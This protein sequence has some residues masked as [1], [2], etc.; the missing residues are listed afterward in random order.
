MC[1]LYVHTYLLATYSCTCS[2]RLL[3]YHMV[4]SISKSDLYTYILDKDQYSPATP[5]DR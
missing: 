5:A 2:I 3:E 4:L 1:A